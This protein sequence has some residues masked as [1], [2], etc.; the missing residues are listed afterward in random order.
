[1]IIA[2][3][4]FNPLK[5][6]RIENASNDELNSGRY[7]HIFQAMIILFVLWLIFKRISFNSP[8]SFR[9]YL[10]IFSFISAIGVFCFNLYCLSLI[11]KR[12]KQNKNAIENGAT[13]K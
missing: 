10:I 7:N 9:D 4:L 3:Y 1:M 13:K 12:I 6:K 8:Q 2:P 11:F 5:F